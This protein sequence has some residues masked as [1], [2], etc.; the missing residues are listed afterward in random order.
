MYDWQKNLL[1]LAEREEFEQ[2]LAS[3]HAALGE[4]AFTAAWEEGRAMT[5]QQAVAYALEDYKQ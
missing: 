1:S 2:A 3:I 5:P 4:D